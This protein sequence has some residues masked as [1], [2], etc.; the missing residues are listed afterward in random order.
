VDTSS[1][2]PS[3][4][5]RMTVW[6]ALLLVAALAWAIV[7]QQNRTMFDVG[8]NQS[9]PD[10][11]G[12]GSGMSDMSSM[13]SGSAS[14]PADPTS[15]WLYLPLWTSMMV[16]MMFPAVAPV[17]SLFVTISQ[18]R[19]AANQRAAPTWIFLAGYLAVWS[20]LGV[21]AYLLS[22]VLPALGMMATGLRVEYPVAAGLVLIFAGLYQFSPLK[23]VCLRHCRSPLSVILH[24]WHDGNAGSFRMGFEHGAYCLGCCWGLMLVLFVVGMMNL[25]GMVIL[26]AIIFIEKVVPYGQT[27]GKLTALG[28]IIMGLI[29]LAMPILRQAAG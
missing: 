16:A 12:M 24:G 10:M 20:L 19:R 3:R 11:S 15:I 26:S 27:I 17:V 18:N 25:V 7:V 4:Q 6:L 13:N 21:A 2:V 1:V 5:T 28:L 9:A 8:V 23:R 22:R 14:I 29:T